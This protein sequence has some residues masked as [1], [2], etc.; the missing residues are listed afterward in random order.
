MHELNVDK[1]LKIAKKYSKIEK[2]TLDILQE[3]TN[4]IIFHHC[5]EIK[6]YYKNKT[7]NYHI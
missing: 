7:W 6:I 3:F 4:K 5:E 1:F 2:L